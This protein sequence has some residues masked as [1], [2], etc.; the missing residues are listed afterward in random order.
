MRNCEISLSELELEYGAR[1][2]ASET[3]LDFV[4]YTTPRWSPGPIHI[5]ICEQ[6]DRV[7]RGE[8]DRL[9][10]LCPPQHGKS[11]ATSKRAPAYLLGH[12]P[13]ED[14][15]QVSASADLAEGFGQDVRN[16]MRSEEYSHV[17]QGVTLREDS[18]ARGRWHTNHGGS[19]YAVG[20]GGQ[21]YGRGGM[22]IID[23]PFGT[24][25]D[26]QSELQRAKVWDWY[27]GTLYNRVRPGKPIVVIQ[28]R[29]HEDDLVGRLLAQQAAGGDRWE[30]V[31]LPA[32]INDPPWPERYDRD[33]LI[34]IRDNMD[35][36]QWEAL[37]MQ[38]PT[39]DEGT[40]FKREWFEMFD[41]DSLPKSH[42]YTSG[43][44]AVTE[45]GG[46]CT[47]IATHA[48]SGQTLYLGVDGWHGQTTADV[49]I[50]RLIDQVAKLKPLAFF[51]EGGPIRRA[52]EPFLARRMLERNHWVRCE[53]VTRGRDKPTE[54]RS[55]QA[56]A[57]MGRIKIAD[58]EY[59]HRLLGQLLKFPSGGA[60]D[61]VDMAVNM[62]KA[63]DEAHPAI[64][65]QAIDP[66]PPKF[67]VQRSITEIIAAKT[68]KRK[69]AYL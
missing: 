52:V 10:L 38:N 35:R 18:Q 29:M 40:Y 57:G 22:A 41:P 51:G 15:I 7:R 4:A 19:Y 34:R 20:I 17:F 11:T 67:P 25:G 50:E 9:M 24:W 14:I 59:G 5:A 63:I 39:P 26:A 3:M 68:A 66:P 64:I 58:T 16:C 65:P 23:D 1:L 13:S 56:M 32:D 8:I 12:D 61:A 69:A 49:W 54:A 42:M 46:D 28:H 55:L 53:W 27:T 43:D 48:Y 37:Y 31:E 33:A 6:L 2:A 21:L 47:D 44:F 36:R 60:D 30:V 45:G 62:T